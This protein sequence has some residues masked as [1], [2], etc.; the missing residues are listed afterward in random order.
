M[1]CSIYAKSNAGRFD[2]REPFTETIN[3]QFLLAYDSPAPYA[4]VKH[5]LPCWMDSVQN[6]ILSIWFPRKNY[7]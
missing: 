2:G 4:K 5:C 6:D 1:M 7:S 3:K